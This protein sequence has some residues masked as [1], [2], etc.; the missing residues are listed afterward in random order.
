[1]NLNDVLPWLGLLVLLFASGFFSASETALFSL[2]PEQ[3]ARAGYRA[4]RLLEQPRDLL[5]G[6]LLGSV[7]VNLSFFASAPMVLAGAGFDHPFYGGLGAVLVLVLCGEIFPKTLAL[8]APILVARLCSLPLGPAVYLLR[9]LGRGVTAFLEVSMRAL[10]DAAQP[11]R[12]I[13]VQALGEALE[14]SAR[15]GLLAPGEA[16]LLAEI[17]ELSSLRVREIMTPRVDVLVLDF[18]TG[19][20]EHLRVL[21]EAM[22]RRYNWLPVVRGGADNVEGFVE[23]RKLVAFPERSLAEQVM[24]VKFVPE[25]ARV[26]MVLQSLREDRV[27]EA[28]VIDEY[29]GMAGV[30][31]LERIFEE[32]VGDLRVEGEALERPVVPLGED[33]FRVLGSLSI[34]DWNDAFGSEV[35]PTEFETVGGFVTAMLGRIPAQGDRVELDS[36]LVLTVHEV[37]GRRVLAVDISLTPDEARSGRSSA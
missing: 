35:V 3:R 16:D 26:L 2:R 4:V 19:S 15:Q 22:A 10:G 29:G 24:P 12:P 18:E 25:V 14:R 13:S 30:V 11:E 33:R 17:I 7:L 36:G 9:P 23:L 8:R 6:V 21:K 28:V 20:E 37:R 34:R 5:V 1:V 27:G 31:T 32:L